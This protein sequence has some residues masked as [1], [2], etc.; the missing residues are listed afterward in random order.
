M[1][2][3]VFMVWTFGCRRC[4]V[5]VART[6]SL[7]GA[8]ATRN[9]CGWLFVP[10]CSPPP[11]VLFG[12][13]ARGW[14]RFAGANVLTARCRR[15]LLPRAQTCSE[16]LLLTTRRFS[17][18]LY[19]SARS[20]VRDGILTYIANCVAH[21]GYRYRHNVVWRAPDSFLFSGIAFGGWVDSAAATFIFQHRCWMLPYGFFSSFLSSFSLYLLSF[22]LPFLSTWWPRWRAGAEDVPS[23]PFLR[24]LCLP[25]KVWD[26]GAWRFARHGRLGCSC[27]YR[28][29]WGDYYSHSTLRHFWERQLAVGLG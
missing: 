23:L 7:C 9:A 20:G 27:P 12:F 2:R 11:A 22:F 3:D 17:S 1:Y 15:A 4:V 13:R 14:N 24:Q 16:G 19:L 21:S 18:L 8:D 28:T 10:R 6:L 26:F 5:A 25:S 29:T